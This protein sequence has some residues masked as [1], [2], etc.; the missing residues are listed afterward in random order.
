MTSAATVLGMRRYDIFN[1]DA[2]GICALHQ[3]RL[4]QPCDAVL[5]TG[6]K[7]D[8]ALFEKLPTAQALD[9]TALDIS[10]DR[11][12]EPIRQTLAAGSR[13]RYFDHHAAEHLF[14][15]PGLESHIDTDPDV[16]SSLLVDRHL[17]G[18]FRRWTCVGAYGDNL[19]GLAAP[20]AERAGCTPEVCSALSRLGYLLNY[21]AYGETTDDLHIHPA[22]LYQ[23]L[24]RFEC[25]L[26]FIAKA[27][28]YKYLEEGHATDQRSMLALTPLARNAAAAVYL[29]PGESW[30]RRLCGS[31]ANQ[32]MAHGQGQSIAVLTPSRDGSFGVNV[33]T[34]AMAPRAD[35]FCKRYPGGGGR[36]VAGGID[37]LPACDVDRVVADFFQYIDG[38]TV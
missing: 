17:G 16:C 21:N 2:D 11:N 30:A 13:I 3:L 37:K 14:A 1:G 5:L 7:R 6:V 19:P 26:D 9:I 25:P 10:F 24:H 8:I 18:L 23:S 36:H 33:R 12:L 38:D 34:A 22:Q 20:L 29:L 15:H 35:K 27:H 32:L 28:E 4:L 31:L